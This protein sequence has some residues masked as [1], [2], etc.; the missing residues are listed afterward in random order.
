MDKWMREWNKHL[1]LLVTNRLA[2]AKL[3]WI[4]N[5]P[6]LLETHHTLSHE[7]LTGD[8]NILPFS[9]SGGSGFIGSVHGR[10]KRWSFPRNKIPKGNIKYN[11]ET[12]QDLQK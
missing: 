6:P 1:Y 8:P 10:E 11:M 12:L 5:Q 9:Y 7:I 2:A 3:G 4:W